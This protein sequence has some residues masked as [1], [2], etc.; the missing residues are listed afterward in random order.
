MK[1]FMSKKMILSLFALFFFQ[2]VFGDWEVTVKPEPKN[3]I[4]RSIVEF[5]NK[6]LSVTY[7]PQLPPYGLVSHKRLVFGKRVLFLT[8]WAHGAHSVL[9]RVFYPEKNKKHP[10]CEM[11]SF[12]E[13]SDLQIKNK[14][15]KIKITP[16]DSGVPKSEWA[17]CYSLS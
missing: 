1:H 12:S 16:E 7:R 17:L 4:I 11:I 5:K 3:E 6:S 13:K 10:L 9:F 2:P 15:L 14:V 8:G